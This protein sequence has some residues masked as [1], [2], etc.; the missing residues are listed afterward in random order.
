MS[1]LVSN[2]SQP[3]D[4][5]TNPKSEGLRADKILA[6]VTKICKIKLRLLYQEKYFSF[7]KI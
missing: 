2:Q 5:Q 3:D 7:S 4:E 6:K 1:W